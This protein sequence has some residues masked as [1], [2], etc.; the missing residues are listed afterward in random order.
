MAFRQILKDEEEF[1]S[2]DED[3][4]GLDDHTLSDSDTNDTINIKEVS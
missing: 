1:D 2:S 4:F 3:L